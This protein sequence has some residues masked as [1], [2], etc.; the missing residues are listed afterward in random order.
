MRLAGKVAVVTG[1]GDG[2]GRATAAAFARE[3]AAVVVNDVVEESAEKVVTAIQS[4]GGRAVAAVTPV[5]TVEAA[6]LLV[7]AAIDRFGDL[8]IVVNNAAVGGDTALAEIPDE[9]ILRSLNTNLVGAIYLVREAVSRVMIPARYG[10]IISMTSRSGLRGKPGES[11]YA[12]GKAGLV[13]A[14]LAWALELIPYQITVNCVAP[15]AWTRLL[16]IMPEPERSN[17]IAKR[18]HNVL[19]RVAMPDD[20]AP[21]LVFLASDDAAYLTGQI[22]EATGQPAALL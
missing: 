4:E 6:R 18:Q 14:S 7:D 20:V 9:Q 2:I 12:A 22:I 13:G 11:V 17:T 16:E 10:R 5:G 21:T 3:G 19:Q 1:A 15:A 8:H